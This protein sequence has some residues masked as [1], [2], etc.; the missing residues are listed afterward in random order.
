MTEFLYKMV[1]INI[2]SADVTVFTSVTLMLGL[3]LCAHINMYFFPVVTAPK[4]TACAPHN[5]SLIINGLKA[6]Y[7]LAK[8]SV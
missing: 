5:L 7:Y 4:Q 1:L 2:L 6:C 8:K 3:Y